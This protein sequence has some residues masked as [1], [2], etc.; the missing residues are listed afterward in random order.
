MI[1]V[2]LAPLTPLMIYILALGMGY[3]QV[4]YVSLHF[5]ILSLTINIFYRYNDY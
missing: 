2:Q 5:T 3:H 4:Q 1:T